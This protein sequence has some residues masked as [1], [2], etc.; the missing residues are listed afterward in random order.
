M[1]KP[2]C[3]EGTWQSRVTYTAPLVSPRSHGICSPPLHRLMGRDGSATDGAGQGASSQTRGGFMRSECLAR[4]K[5]RL[6]SHRGEV[7]EE[8]PT[9]MLCWGEQGWKWAWT[10]LPEGRGGD[11]C[12]SS[13]HEKSERNPAT[14]VD[15]HLAVFLALH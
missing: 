3:P 4:A 6:K 10:A 15:F 12:F 5:P 8:L 13:H 11:T 2:Q 1:G 14:E 9:Q 7:R